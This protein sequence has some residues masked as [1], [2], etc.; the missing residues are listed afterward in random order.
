MSVQALAGL[1]GLNLWIL[2]VGLSLLFALREWASWSEVL[3]LSGLAYLLGLAVLGVAWVWELVGGLP[4]SFGTIFGTGVAIGGAAIAAGRRLGRRLPARPVARRPRLPDLPLE[5]AVFGGVSIVYLE[6]LF[7]AGRLAGLYE[8][9]AWSFWIPKAKAIYFF[10]GLDPQFFRELANPSYPPFVPVLEAAAFH[11]MGGADEVTIHLQFWFVLVGF[12]A[13]VVGL[14][15]RR[16]PAVL[17]WPMLLMTLATPHLVGHALQ[18]QA[19]VALDVFVAAAALLLG[20]WLLDRLRWQLWSAGLL[21]AAAMETKR[22]G[23][24]FAACIIVAALVATRRE[25]RALWPA[26]LTTGVLA[27]AAGIPWRV[28]LAVRDLGG[29]GPE[30]GGTGLFSHLGRAWPSLRLALSS[31]FDFDIWLI[32]M[33]LVLLALVGAFAVRAGILATYV[34]GFYVLGVA[35]LTWSTWAFPSLPITKN[36][37]LNPIVRLTGSLVLAVPALVP[38][39]LAFAW[40][41]AHATGEAR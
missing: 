33:P 25:L 19:D 41:G 23:Y 29:G 14:L 31:L 26:L 15:S 11:F 4:L 17:L 27:G 16:V 32:A 35:G 37:A 21:L 1:V 34:A 28:L 39:L 2:V 13:A 22:E 5:A 8:F 3:R 30:A 9:D 36:D 6:A 10:G 40:R 7:R 20:L 12:V 24:L 38:L 18:P